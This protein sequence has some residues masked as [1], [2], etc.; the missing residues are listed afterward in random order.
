[1]TT[2]SPWYGNCLGPRLSLPADW[3]QGLPFPGGA[4]GYFGYDL[5]RRLERLPAP[6]PD[7][8]GLPQ[9]AIGF[10]D[11]ALVVDHGEGRTWLVGRRGSAPETRDLLFR[12]AH[13]DLPYRPRPFTLSGPLRSNMD[14]AA[15]ARNFTRVQAWIQAG[16]CYQVNLARRFSVAAAGDPWAA[17]LEL[18]RLSPAPFAAYLN[19]PGGRL[20]SSSPERFLHLAGDAVETRPIKG[21]RP[22]GADPTEDRRQAAELAASPKIVP[23]TS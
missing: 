16:D 10:Y 11:Q 8:L 6:G 1:M 13:G 20:L 4:L 9:L 3:P 17:Y 7:A 12:L 2:R 5:A 18:R 15:Y 19:T 21:T 14:A 22:R 23:R